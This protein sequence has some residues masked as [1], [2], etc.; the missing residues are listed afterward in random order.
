MKSVVLLVVEVC[1]DVTWKNPPPLSACS[2]DKDWTLQSLTQALFCFSSADD[3]PPI[4]R[5]GMDMRVQPGET[6]MLRGT[7]ST[8][9]RGIVSY[10][11]KQVLGDPSVEMEV[12][13]CRKQAACSVSPVVCTRSGSCSHWLRRHLVLPSL[14]QLTHEPVPKSYGALLAVAPRHSHT[15]GMWY[16]LATS[17]LRVPAP[18]CHLRASW[19]T[20]DLPGWEHPEG[21]SFG[22]RAS[23]A[24]RLL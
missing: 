16:F 19:A 9:D 3:H 18:G 24:P 7:E 4:A 10:E 23:S 5:T 8:D 2:R 20:P 13:T 14:S 11:W 12:G 17:G 22:A 6:V 15:T 21:S 1:I